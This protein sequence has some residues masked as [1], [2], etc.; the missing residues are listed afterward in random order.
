M[1]ALPAAVLFDLDDT[2]FAH[3]AAVDRGIRAHMHAV[4]IAPSD[5]AA[6]LAAVALWRDLEE[7]H[8]H[9]YLLGE[10]DYEAQRRDRARDFAA[11][12]GIEL[13]D[14]DAAAWFRAYVEHYRAAWALHDDAL[15][16][17]TRLRELRPDLRIGLI[18]NGDEEFQQRK[19]RAVDLTT[20]LDA[21]LASGTLGFAKPDPRIFRHA[22]DVLGVPVGDAA[23]VG[24]RLRT[25]AI[26][27]ASAGLTGVWLNRR[28][29]TP[30]PAEAD[31]ARALGVVEISTLDE[32]VEALQARG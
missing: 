5:T 31:E 19:V 10:V 28:G 32:L 17:L 3:R 12:H 13:G 23:Y 29:L 30:P 21:V 6:E 1:S 24:D 9:R 7:R 25:D 26:G 16:C 27:A 20:R 14:A 11:Q 15:R 2:L 8:Y 22:C 4:G 18:T